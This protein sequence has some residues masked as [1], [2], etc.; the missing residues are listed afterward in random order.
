MVEKNFQTFF[1]HWLANNPPMLAT[2]YELKLEKKGSMSFDRVYDHQIAGLRQA[3][4]KGMYHKIADQPAAFV[5][6]R[7]VHFGSKKPFDCMFLKGMEAYV[8]VMF[9]TPMAP[10]EAIFIEIDDFVKEKETS[11]RRSITVAR[12]KEISSLIALM[13]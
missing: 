10:K 7:R 12:A 6:G 9:Y 4:Y 13:S 2:V 5:E 3:K 1:K 11:K 8:V